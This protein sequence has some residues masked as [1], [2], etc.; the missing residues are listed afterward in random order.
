MTWDRFVVFAIAAAFMGW[1]NVAPNNFFQERYGRGF[2][3]KWTYDPLTRPRPATMT[4]RPISG[5]T[6]RSIAGVRSIGLAVDLVIRCF[7]GTSLAVNER[8]T[9]LGGG[10]CPSQQSN[11]LILFRHTACANPVGKG[12]A[13]LVDAV[14]RQGR[15][16]ASRSGRRD[17]GHSAQDGRGNSPAPQVEG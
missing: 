9:S 10:R 11:E 15:H 6:R 5:I 13:T 17:V 12:Q 3:L 7:V 16:P 2:P 1:A 8:A 14:R 4:R